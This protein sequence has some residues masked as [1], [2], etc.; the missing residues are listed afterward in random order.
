MNSR[1]LFLH[2]HQCLSKA[3]L[4]PRSCL[5][6][7]GSSFPPPCPELLALL[8]VTL[9]LRVIL[10]T[11]LCEGLNKPPIAWVIYHSYT[12]ICPRARPA[13]AQVNAHLHVR[14]RHT[15]MCT[16]TSSP[17]TRKCTHA[18][19]APA[20][21]YARVHVRPLHMYMRTCTSDPGTHICTCARPALAHVYAHL[22]IQ[23]RHTYMHT[24]TSGSCTRICMRAHP[25]IYSPFAHPSRIQQ[26]GLYPECFLSA[27]APQD[28]ATLL[29]GVTVTFLP[30]LGLSPEAGDEWNRPS[31]SES[32]PSRAPL[33]LFPSILQP[34]L[35]LLCLSHPSLG[36]MTEENTGRIQHLYHTPLHWPCTHICV[37][38]HPHF[39]SS[40]P[41]NSAPANPPINAHTS[42]KYTHTYVHTYAHIHTCIPP[43]T[44]IHVHTHWSHT[45][46]SPRHTHPRSIP[47]SHPAPK[48][49]VSGGVSDSGETSRGAPLH[50]C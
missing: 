19:S 22:H 34:P 49:G 29:T 46:T 8:Q 41:L 1:N 36:S 50:P 14:P 7:S 38:A 15:Y 48:P 28:Q 18:H 30:A 16:C 11:L 40:Q 21:V 2:S 32:L 37:R 44:G 4:R 47:Q 6:P 10:V 31:F 42:H 5:P 3:T 43:H 26:Q 24:C 45:N 13:P 20:H 35:S 17:C 27:E 39:S 25:Y 33:S 12:H 9:F 23:P